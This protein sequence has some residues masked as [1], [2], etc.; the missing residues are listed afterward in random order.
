MSVVFD[1]LRIVVLIFIV[2]LI[3]R[4]VF[5]WIQFF[6]RDWKP[7]GAVLVIAEVVYSVT[8]LALVPLR[9]VLPPLKVGQVQ[10]DLA[11]FVIFF[12]ATILYGFLGG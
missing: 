11:F 10:I 1:A 3:G 7:A 9:K 4:L 6:S 8:D 12:I 5:D 2:L